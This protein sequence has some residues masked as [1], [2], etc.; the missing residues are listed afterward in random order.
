MRSRRLAVL[1][2]LVVGVGGSFAAEPVTIAVVKVHD[3]DTLDV[4]VN[5][6]PQRWRLIGINTPETHEISPCGRVWAQRAQEALTALVG[7]GGLRVEYDVVPRDKYDRHLVYLY[8]SDV[9]I[10]ERLLRD[11]YGRVGTMGRNRT[12]AWVFGQAQTAARV[13]KLGMWADGW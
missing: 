4:M 5:G 11:G 1:L 6:E 8:A 2:I 3:G 10:N 13:Q 9:F 7:A 12:Y